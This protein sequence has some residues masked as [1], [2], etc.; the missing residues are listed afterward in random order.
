MATKATQQNAD[1]P[2]KVLRMRRLVRVGLF[3]C[4]STFKSDVHTKKAYSIRQYSINKHA[5][6]SHK[7][8]ICVSSSTKRYIRPLVERS[9]PTRFVDT[10]EAV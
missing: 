5:L 10:M 7:V 4:Q 8:T 9:L 2:C 6:I 3:F 1:I